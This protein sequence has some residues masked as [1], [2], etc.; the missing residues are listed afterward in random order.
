MKH[1]VYKSLVLLLG[2][3]GICLWCLRR[4]HR[5]VSKPREVAHLNPGRRRVQQGLRSAAPPAPQTGRRR[6]TPEAQVR[7][8]TLFPL[9]AP[10]PS[11]AVGGRLSASPTT[12]VFGVAEVQ[13][14]EQG[15]VVEQVL[16]L[17]GLRTTEAAAER[18]RDA[19]RAARRSCLILEL[20]AR[21]LL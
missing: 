16:H 1:G 8:S 17:R 19:L 12:K 5:G 11:A 21:V 4:Q 3:V 7:Q 6:A 9:P 15:G 20:D 14:F 10:P 18:D 2:I 13:E